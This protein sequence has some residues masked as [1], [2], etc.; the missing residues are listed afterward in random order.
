MLRLGGDKSAVSRE[1]GI[2]ATTLWRRL[3]EMGW[4]SSVLPGENNETSNKYHLR[5]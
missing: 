2:S 5:G 3:K 4:N 1:L